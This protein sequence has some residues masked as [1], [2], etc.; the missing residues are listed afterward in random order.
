MTGS[1]FPPCGA[2]EPKY[3]LQELLEGL[4]ES[5]K[6]EYDNLSLVPIRAILLTVAI[7]CMAASVGSQLT[8]CFASRMSTIIFPF[9]NNMVYW[10]SRNDFARAA[11]INLWT[12]NANN[13]GMVKFSCI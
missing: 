10:S 11:D 5:S 3:P 8:M 4:D 12:F 6:P 7:F 1:D 9:W 2:R 13:S